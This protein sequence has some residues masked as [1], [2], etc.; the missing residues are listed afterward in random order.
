MLL[1]PS[2]DTWRSR[3]LQRQQEREEERIQLEQEEEAIHAQETY[4]LHKYFTRWVSVTSEEKATMN[5]A[6][7]RILRL[8]LFNAWRDHTVQ[9][10]LKARQHVFKKILAKWQAKRADNVEIERL[11]VRAYEINLAK[12]VFWGWFWGFC[13]KRAPAFWQDNSKRS[14][15]KTWSFKSRILQI[16]LVIAEGSRKIKT[17]EAFYYAWAERC[18]VY[19]ELE[20]TATERYERKRREQALSLWHRQHQLMAV[21]KKAE[22]EIGHILTKKLLSRWRLR[23]Q[24]EQY[25]TKFSNVRILKG[26]LLLW[27]HQCRAKQLEQHRQ[28]QAFHAWRLAVQVKKANRIFCEKLLRKFMPRLMK[29][30]R[31][32]VTTTEFLTTHAEDVH[33]HYL[34][35]SILRKWRE[36]LAA[37]DSL[38]KRAWNM[39]PAPVIKECLT[40]WVSAKR[41]TEEMGKWAADAEFYLIGNRALAKLRKATEASKKERRK[42]AYAQARR[43]NKLNLAKLMLDKWRLKAGE[44]GEINA[45]ATDMLENK[46][47]AI[48]TYALKVWRVKSKDIMELNDFAGMSRQRKALGWW[49]VRLSQAD[50]DLAIAEESD[51]I[52]LRARCLK[53]W[54]REALQYRAHEHLVSELRDKRAKR[55]LRLAFKHWRQTLEI[56]QNAGLLFDTHAPNSH[57]PA[58]AAPNRQVETLINFDESVFRS[59]VKPHIKDMSPMK[60]TPLPAYLNTPSRRSTL[61]KSMANIVSTTPAGL[62][63]PFERQLRAQLSGNTLSAY[64]RRTAARPLSKLRAFDDLVEEVSRDD[65][66]V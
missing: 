5:D 64:T 7:R 31:R 48:A 8:R 10:Q 49:T 36:R 15:I 45:T 38:P 40:K 6:R 65:D 50:R 30:T 32:A 23:S 22:R 62:S 58:A 12:R 55:S 16:N 34:K 52:R 13:E 27:R 14:K 25:A 33:S 54:S 60:A 46:T 66:E 41:K 28:R 2:F 19:R 35:T 18:R 4:L 39:R 9:N 61:A 59:P 3:F 17:E 57:R 26:A 47:M 11:S 56:R 44:V 37:V 1:R 43:Q 63:T 53:K 24:Q 21:K 42:T 51:V 29:T 20:I